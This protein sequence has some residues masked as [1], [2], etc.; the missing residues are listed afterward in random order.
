[1]P[2]LS[3]ILSLPLI[4]PA[5]AQKHVTHNEALRLLDV[6]VQLSVADRILTAPPVA[7]VVGDRH[8]VAAGASGAWAGQAGKVALFEGA[9]WAFFA[10]LTGWRAYIEAEAAVASFDGTGWI[11]LA[12]GP[13]EVGQLGV[14]A[15]PDATNRLSVQSPATLLS[16]VGAGHQVKI[17]K[18][19]VGDTASLMF[20]T[21]Y[22]GRAEIGTTGSDALAVKV[23]PNGTTF[24]AAISVA[25][26]S[27]VVSLP[28]GLNASGSALRDGADPSKAAEFVV[29]AGPTA[30]LRSYTLPSVSG[31]FALL[32]GT[33]TFGGAKT[34]SGTT[35]VSAAQASIG[36]ATGTASYGLG[37]GATLA[38]VT[39]TVNLGTAG[40]SGSVTVVNVGSD[41]AGAGG[42]LVVNSPTVSFANSVTAIA[43]PQAVVGAKYL[44]LG[45]AVG[46]ATNR[47]SVNSPAVLLNNAGAGIEATLNKVAAGNDAAIAFKTGFSARALVGLLGNDDFSVKVSPNGSSYADALIVAAASGA[48]TL[49][50]PVVLAGQASDPASP[51]NGMV[52]HDNTVGR[53]KA[54]LGG[55]TQILDTGLEAPHL[56]PVAGDYVLT[57]TGAGGGA[58]GTQAG[59]AGRLEIFPYA[60]RS[61]LS[62]DRLAINCTTLLAAALA[63]LVVYDSDAFGRPG[64]L[65]VETGDLDLSTVGVKVATVSTVLRKGR[66]YWFGLRHSSTATVSHW[67]GTATPDINGGAAP[68]TTARKVLRRSLAY[69]T[70]APAIWGFVSSEITAALAPAVWLRVL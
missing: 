1:M 15:A 45:G 61:D 29:S 41:V 59:A 25:G 36:T 13:L 58:T 5:Q 14:S 66:T 56:M 17:N 27:G 44:G 38:G 54:R 24:Y 11:A 67:A 64:A 55:V 52:W 40:V 62:V 35:V 65:M 12:D 49:S 63:K 46:D 34:F 39:K 8:I 33:Q 50:Q 57:T 51:V 53:L 19:A 68:V 31:E 10:P 28:A 32:G 18:A 69:G 43:A 23:S 47:L 26:A 37:A 4:L 30:T 60:A 16:H 3:P 7:P 42:S 6:M 21:G 70:Q 20:Q 9:A 22:S 2:D 48:V